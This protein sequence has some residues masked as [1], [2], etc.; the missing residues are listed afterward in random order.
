MTL[1]QYVLV[2]LL[3]LTATSQAQA[4]K[5]KKARWFEVEMILF[6]RDV[7]RNQL[8]ENFPD[9]IN[10]IKINKS[11]DFMS[12]YLPTNPETLL[13]HLPECSD[14]VREE[15]DLSDYQGVLNREV[16]KSNKAW[17]NATTFCDPYER[18]RLK[19]EQGDFFQEPDS[20]FWHKIPLYLPVFERDKT[21]RTH[22]VAK[23]N[24]MFKRRVQ[25]IDRKS[26]LTP[27]LHLAWRQAIW[28]Q[29]VEKPWRIKA[30]KNYSKQFNY[31]GSAI[32]ENVDSEENEFDNEFNENSYSN[33]APVQYQNQ[34]PTFENQGM[35]HQ[36]IMDN[37]LGFV[38]KVKEGQ[39][40]SEHAQQDKLA[41]QQ[42]IIAKTS[43]L[44]QDVW[45]IDGLFKI[46]LR[47]YLFIE[48]QFNMRRPDRLIR[49][50]PASEL[51]NTHASSQ[52]VN[53]NTNSFALN[54]S[55]VN[56]STQVSTVNGNMIETSEPYLYAYEFNQKRRIRSKEI[57]YFDHPMMGMVI[58]VR[59]YSL[60]K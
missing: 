35:D 32:P 44:P 22:L 17:R 12:A 33:N 38:D 60:P 56:N 14:E 47:H 28:S 16:L 19:L 42:A 54:N 34:I 8:E 43:G 48:A 10:P 41:E 59:R 2:A 4:A 7:D 18:S 51:D 27:V 11:R 45:E 25:L 23:D 31:D 49:S 53:N 57:H 30:G 15:V 21:N 58:Q 52:M 46:Y 39:W 9:A 3:G 20:I 55:R 24:L 13:T 26:D 50:L 36:K 40:Q 37:I 6:T 5:E 1:R 29:K